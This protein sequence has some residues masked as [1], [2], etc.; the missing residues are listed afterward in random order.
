MNTYGGIMKKRIHF[1]IMFLMVLFNIYPDEILENNYLATLNDSNVRL[2]TEPNLNSEIITL[3]NMN[4]TVTILGISE[5]RQIIENM[6][7]HWFNIKTGNN[8]IGW[9]YGFYLDVFY[10]NPSRYRIFDLNLLRLSRSKNV[11]D[12]EPSS[13]NKYLGYT[14]YRRGHVGNVYVYEKYVAMGITNEENGYGALGYYVYKYNPN[15]L[16]SEYEIYGVR[17]ATII[18]DYYNFLGIYNNSIL[19]DIGTAPVLRGL[20][21]Y[22]LENGKSIFKGV[23]DGE[24]VEIFDLNKVIV[25]KQDWNIDT[26][27]IDKKSYKEIIHAYSFDL[28]NYELENL[29]KTKELIFGYML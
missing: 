26:I 3:L 29:N 27:N 7:S 5:E 15:L 11:L 18:D 8:K 2:R 10:P 1:I 20:E 28:N 13:N 24:K 6:D 12:I 19:L 23:W 25:Y 9:V 22:N 21:I 16:F 17:V 14:N 4:E